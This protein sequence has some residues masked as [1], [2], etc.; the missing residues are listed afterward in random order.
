[1][2]FLNIIKALFVEIML[3][4]IVIV[5]VS[6]FLGSSLIKLNHSNVVKKELEKTIE[7]INKKSNDIK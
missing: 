1:M 5:I 3:I 2:I 7:Q 4:K 6:A